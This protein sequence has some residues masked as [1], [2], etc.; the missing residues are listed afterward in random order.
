MTQ[1]CH[2]RFHQVKIVVTGA[3]TIFTL[4]WQTKHMKHLSHLHDLYFVPNPK[5]NMTDVSFGPMKCQWSWAVVRSEIFCTDSTM[6]HT[7]ALGNHGNKT[8]SD[9]TGQMSQ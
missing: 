7:V 2:N 4:M 9:E 6:V 1:L 8:T 3:H 5:L